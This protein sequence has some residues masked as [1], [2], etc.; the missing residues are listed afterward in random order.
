MKLLRWTAEIVSDGSEFRSLAGR[1]ARLGDGTSRNPSNR[2][3][4]VDQRVKDLA[5]IISQVRGFSLDGFLSDYE[6]PGTS[7]PWSIGKHAWVE[8]SRPAQ[9]GSLQVIRKDD[10]AHIMASVGVAPKL[11][12]LYVPDYTVPSQRIALTA[13][14]HREIS[15]LLPSY[16]IQLALSEGPF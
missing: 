14:L 2:D 9:A 6:E 11:K 5:G 12:V 3:A 10:I 15:N 7:I 16:E 1:S 13:K 8:S 4:L